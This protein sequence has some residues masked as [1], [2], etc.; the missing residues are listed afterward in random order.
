VTTWQTTSEIHMNKSF[1][2]AAAV[3]LGILASFGAQAQSDGTSVAVTAE[4]Q[5]YRMGVNE[6]SEFANTYVLTNGQVARFI[7]RGNHYYVQLKDSARVV[8]GFENGGPRTVS[9]RLRPVG[10]NAFVTDSGAEL[11]FHDHAEEVRISG[12]E[13]LPAARVAANSTNVQMVA[14][15]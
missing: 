15:R 3:A 12:F 6:F 4:R 2:G 13:R 7:Q 10:P 5:S 9:T 11:T 8:P 1:I 14:R